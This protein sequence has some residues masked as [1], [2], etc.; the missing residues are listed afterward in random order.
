M[1]NIRINEAESIFEPFWDSGDSYPD[2]HKY[3]CLKNY[4]VDAEGKGSVGTAWMCVSVN[5]NG[6]CSVSMK[7][8]ASLD[9]SE[10]DIFRFFGAVSG[11]L[12]FIINIVIDGI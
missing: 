2:N 8:N 5:V 1:R 11:K 10:Y 4:E 12:K 9:V 3:S 6:G 7:R